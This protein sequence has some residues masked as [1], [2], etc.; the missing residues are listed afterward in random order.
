MLRVFLDVPISEPRSMNFYQSPFNIAQPMHL[1]HYPLLL[2]LTAVAT[3]ALAQTTEKYPVNFEKNQAITYNGRQLRNVSLQSADGNQTHAVGTRLVYNDLTENTFTALPGDAVKVNVD[4]QTGATPWMH[5]YVF[6]DLNNDG[7]FA[8]DELLSYS[9][10]KGKNS[11]GQSIANGATGAGNSLQPPTFQLAKDLAEGK[12]RMRVKVDW[13]NTDPAG[14]KG[15]DGTATGKN[16]IVTNGG[17]IADFTLNVHATAYPQMALYLD[18]QHANIYAERGALPI[19]PQRGK[20]LTLR[21]VPVENTYEA[22]QL[23]VRFGKDP[24][25]EQT[26]KG[27]QQ[28]EEQTLTPNARGIVTLPAEVM[29]GKV[30]VIAHYKATKESKYLPVF[31]DEFEGKDHSEPNTKVWS[32]TPRRGSTWSRFCSNDTAVVYLRD[33]ELVCRAMAT[34][35]RL[36]GTEPKDFISGGIKSEGKFSFQYG[37]AEA[38]LFTKPHSGNFP[39]L[40]MMP[41]DGSAGW[42]K[43]GEIDIWEQINTESVSYHTLHSHWTF[44]L[45]HKQNPTSAVQ[46]RNI[47]YSRYHTFAVEWTPTL[48]SWY[49]DGELVGSAPKSTDSDALANGQWPYTKPFYLIL[50]Q[51]VGDGSWASSPDPNFVY[52]TRFDWVRVYQTV[53]QNPTLTG[54]ERNVLSPLSP[55]QDGEEYA[56]NAATL[57]YDLSGRRVTAS[58]AH[59]VVVNAQGKKAILSTR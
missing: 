32:R 33:G 15:E 12:Y 47:D 56:D 3:P 27:E 14:A 16:G 31:S 51:S 44:T 55:S 34:P 2:A 10:S 9:Y 41:Q 22:T 50:N 30:R 37:R 4:F 6:V 1:H 59:G 38:R 11:L 53:E 28:W 21:I 29:N 45:K 23:A 18:T 17:A 24:Y 20:A 5:S 35:Q 46:G 52:E 26:V 48:I 39:A 43:A 8:A 13:D 54:I 58:S 57:W 19:Q 42:P 40:W 7:Q 25:A 49:V 36:K